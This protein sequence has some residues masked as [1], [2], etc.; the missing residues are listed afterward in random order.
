MST[1]VSRRITAANLNLDSPEEV[2]EWCDQ[3]AAAGGEEVRKRRL[4]AR[5]ARPVPEK[6]EEPVA[7]ILSVDPR[8]T[9]EQ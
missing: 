2:A 7:T 3:L 5:A 4:A 9:V 8:L 6:P 1:P